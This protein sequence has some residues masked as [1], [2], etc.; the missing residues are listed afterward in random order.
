[1][2][3]DFFKVFGLIESSYKSDFSLRKDLSFLRKWDVL[4]YHLVLV[5]I[6]AIIKLYIAPPPPLWRNSFVRACQFFLNLKVNKCG[7]EIGLDWT[8]Q[9]RNWIFPLPDIR[10]I[11]CYE[12]RVKIERTVTSDTRYPVQMNTISFVGNCPG[13]SR[14]VQYPDIRSNTGHTNTGLD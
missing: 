1:M 13:R 12:I 9:N 3:F 10:T 6:G 14:I 5:P 4:G 7:F 11:V 2:L 8:R